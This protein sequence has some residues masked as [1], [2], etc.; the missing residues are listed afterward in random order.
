MLLA[1]Y[2]TMKVLRAELP[3]IAYLVYAPGKAMQLAGTLVQMLGTRIAAI[4][5]VFGAVDL[6][7]TR[8]EWRRGLRMSKDEVKR[9]HRENDG[10]PEQK[11]ARERAH[12]EMLASASV[13]AVKQAKVLVVNPTHIACALRYDEEEGD[14]APVLLAHGE[15]DLAKRMMEAARAYGIPIV[16]NV[17][18]ARMLKTMTIGEEIPETLYEAVAEILK[19][20]EE[21]EEG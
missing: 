12:H 14:E 18:V 11:A 7:I 21:Q 16:R 10:N 3:S 4:I 17:A 1:V 19:D 9:E 15:G 20:A 6:L 13:T 8:F 2:L 5:L